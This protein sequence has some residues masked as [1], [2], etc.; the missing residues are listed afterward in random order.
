VVAADSEADPPEERFVSIGM[1]ALGRV[2]IV[3]YT[4]RGDSIRII[5]ARIAAA[6]ERA[7]YE[8]GLP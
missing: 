4:Y 1:G 8:A 2:L 3:V 5:S 7:E 6:Q